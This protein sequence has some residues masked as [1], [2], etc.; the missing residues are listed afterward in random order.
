YYG[1]ELCPP[2]CTTEGCMGKCSEDPGAALRQV[3]GTWYPVPLHPG[4]AATTSTGTRRGVT[5][6]WENHPTCSNTR[7]TSSCQ[8]PAV[9]GAC[10]GSSTSTSPPG[11]TVRGSSTRGAS[12]IGELPAA[13]IHRGTNFTLAAPSARSGANHVVSE[14]LTRRA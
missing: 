13:S 7:S 4:D 3:P 12:H 8:V 6:C 5:P 10:R 2:G 11:S 9:S 1:F 14:V